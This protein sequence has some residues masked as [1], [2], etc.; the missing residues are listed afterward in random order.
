MSPVSSPGG[1][2]ND[3]IRELRDTMNDLNKS[4]K[5]SSGIMLVLTIVMAFLAA[6]SVWQGFK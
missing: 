3:A 4:T 6:V 2:D 1:P 5:K